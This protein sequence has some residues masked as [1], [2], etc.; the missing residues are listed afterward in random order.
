MQPVIITN[1]K[2]GVAGV[3]SCVTGMFGAG[4]GAG[5]GDFPGFLLGGIGGLL[6]PLQCCK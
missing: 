4:A 1:V 3:G 5:L 6:L 2:W